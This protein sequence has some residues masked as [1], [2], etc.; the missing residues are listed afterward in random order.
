VSSKR[1]EDAYHP[2][3][4]EYSPELIKEANS[5]YEGKQT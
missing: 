5:E 3:E 1:L 4:I 2:D